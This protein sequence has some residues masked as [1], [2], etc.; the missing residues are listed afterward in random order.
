MGG[1]SMQ[2]RLFSDVSGVLMDTVAPCDRGVITTSLEL[3]DL[4]VNFTYQVGVSGDP[5]LLTTVT[6]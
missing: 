1:C 5:N 4:P 3:P 6:I 2:S